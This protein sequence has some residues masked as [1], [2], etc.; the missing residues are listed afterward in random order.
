MLIFTAF[1]TRSLKK[2]CQFSGRFFVKINLQLYKVKKKWTSISQER[3]DIEI[4]ALIVCFL[5]LSKTTTLF[6]FLLWCRALQYKNL[7]D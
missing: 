6:Q 5:S 4:S 2:Q 7:C 1:E 3:Q